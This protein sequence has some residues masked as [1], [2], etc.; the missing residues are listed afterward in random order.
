MPTAELISRYN[1]RLPFNIPS[2]NASGE[3]TASSIVMPNDTDWQNDEKCWSLKH[4]IVHAIGFPGHTNKVNNSE[5]GFPIYMTYAGLSSTDQRI[6]RMLYS[7]SV[8]LLSNE[9]QVRSY[10][11]THSY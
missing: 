3:M 7:S 2:S 8:P 10:F 1:T 6:I 9:Q 11:A 4:E 5:M